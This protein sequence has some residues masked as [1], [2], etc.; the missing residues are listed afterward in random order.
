ME[1]STR[2]KNAGLYFN[3]LIYKSYTFIYISFN[4]FIEIVY[5]QLKLYLNGHEMST[6]GV[7]ATTTGNSA[8]GVSPPSSLYIGNDADTLSQM[9]AVSVDEIWL[10]PYFI[11]LPSMFT[12]RAESKSRMW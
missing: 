12:I 6:Y 11:Y 1:G 3:S 5:L 4:L 2:S 8:T 10:S 9:A 7:S